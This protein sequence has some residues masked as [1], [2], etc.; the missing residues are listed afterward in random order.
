M[1]KPLIICIGAALIDETFKCYS[2]PLP[3]TSNPAK[4][5]QSMGGVSRNISH[6]LAL[7][8]NNVELIT[9]FG[10]DADGNWM[11]EEC[12]KAGIGINH[13]LTNKSSTGKYAAII[14][15]SGELF[16][17][18][19]S[20]DF[21]N[22]ITI[23][24]LETK[25]HI[26]KNAK[27]IQCDCNLSTESLSWIIRFSQ[28]NNIPCVVEP[29]SIEKA[30]RLKG[31]SLDKVLLLTPNTDELSSIFGEEHKESEDALTQIVINIGLQY[32]WLRNGK[33]GS[34]IYTKNEIYK[35]EAPTVNVV[36]TTG[37]GDA[38]LAGWIHAFL[39]GE[40]I[41]QCLNYANALAK[42]VLG[43]K[44]AIRH[45]LNPEILKVNL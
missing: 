14:S 33:E 7:L 31:L 38:A 40:D 28:K 4:S 1:Q 37:A 30:S 35:K 29:V 12:E 26:L 34:T 19:V 10:D 11:K 9:H 27:L 21:E 41:S 17:A 32:L 44:G 22:L 3:G 15:P 6:H 36:D 20:T 5:S 16:T 45:D 18:A 39:L 42:L 25:T 43:V 23:E 13:S 8:D 24:F 2:D